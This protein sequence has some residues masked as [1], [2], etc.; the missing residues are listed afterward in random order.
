MKTMLLLLAASP[1]LAG[2][3]PAHKIIA[4]HDDTVRRL[5]IASEGEIARECA[6]TD[7]HDTY[8]RPSTKES[9]LDGCFDPRT[10]TL[11]I[12]RK[13]STDPRS[14]PLF[15]RAIRADDQAACERALTRGWK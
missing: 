8:G 6:A 4:T 12:N 13:N 15:C 3:K 11:W 9:I 14:W 10:S 2:C 7:S 1:F 5:V